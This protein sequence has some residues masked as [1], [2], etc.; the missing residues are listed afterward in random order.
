MDKKLK[1]LKNEYMHIAPDKDFKERI[2]KDMKKRPS[3]IRITLSI[4]TAACMCC[5]ITLNA[6]PAISV[7]AQDIP[8]IKQIVNVLT[9]G[10]FE[11]NDGSV[12][13]KIEAPQIDGLLNEELEERL[14]REFKENADVVKEQFI[15]DV[16]ELKENFGDDAHLGVDMSYEILTD[17]E[18]YLVIDVY[19]VNTVASSSTKHTYYNINKNTGE[20]IT[21]EKVFAADKDYREKVSEYIFGEMER[22]NEEEGAMYWTSKD[23]FAGED[24][25]KAVKNFNKFYINEEGDIVI[26]FDKYEIAPGAQGSS[27][28]VLP[29]S[30]TE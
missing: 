9:L 4:T 21:L 26:C 8:V 20:L 22:R 10:R 27:E 24:T 19:I 17:T 29:D 30:I 2:I 25:V 18:A 5:I 15:K 13:A 23:H 14:N 16:Q 1:D 3:K 7:Y 6:V 12:E 11:M 28:F